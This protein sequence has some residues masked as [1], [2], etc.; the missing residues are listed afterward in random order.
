MK[1][2]GR[3]SQASRID[4]VDTITRYVHYGFTQ[5]ILCGMI[6]ISDSFY[7]K[8]RRQI[9]KGIIEKERTPRIGHNVNA[10]LPDEE[11]A[12]IAYAMANPNYYHR[13]LTWR[14]VDE[15]IT[16]MGITTVYRILSKNGLIFPNK[17]RKKY[18]CHH[19]Y[20][21]EAQVPDE[22][23]QTDIT[24]LKYRDRDIYQLSF[25]DVYS[26]FVVISVTLL[27]ME[28]RTVSDVIEAYLK[29]H[30]SELKRIPV[31]QSDNGSPYIGH[32]FK[33]VMRDFE[34]DHV[35]CNPATPTENVIIERW[36]RTSKERL[37]EDDEPDG[38]EEFKQLI[39]TA[40]YYYNYDRYHQSLGY[41]T[42]YD[43]YRGDP[44]K[45]FAERKKYCKIV[46]EERILKNSQ[47]IKS[48]SIKPS[49]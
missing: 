41:V 7:H 6:G 31:I 13:E 4:I 44:A 27:N 28:S 35:Y 5:A 38:F 16:F 2:Y 40:V 20:S 12:V 39:Q 49:T 42:P 24:Y 21:N 14:M 3:I 43:Y 33:G 15:K 9:G 19:R 46:R 47:R 11:Q 34:V 22:R 45:N 25:I 36:H 18:G 29:E 23:W 26:R 17:L 1:R 48:L 30:Q 8:I 37:Y 32:E 10:I